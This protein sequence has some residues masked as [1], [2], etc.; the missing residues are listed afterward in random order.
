MVC[1][2]A[3]QKPW[4]DKKEKSRLG[5]V[6]L[7]KGGKERGSQRRADEGIVVVD[8]GGQSQEVR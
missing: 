7:D 6:I 5:C 1:L 2:T 4:L 3:R 8:C